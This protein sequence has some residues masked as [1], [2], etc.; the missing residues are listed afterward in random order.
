MADTRVN[1]DCVKVAKRAEVVF[2]F[3]RYTAIYMIKGVL[4]SAETSNFYTSLK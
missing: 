3:S 2:Q 4:L 1:A